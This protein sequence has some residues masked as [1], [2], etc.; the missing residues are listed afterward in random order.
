MF[1]RTTRLGIA[2][3]FWLISSWAATATGQLVPVPL[4]TAHDIDEYCETSQ[5]Q[6]KSGDAQRYQRERKRHASTTFSTFV[7]H[8]HLPILGYDE[9]RG[10][11]EIPIFKEVPIVDGVSIA[12][13]REQVLRFS[14][15]ER[16]AIDAEA[17]YKLGRARLEL[18]F[19]PASYAKWDQETCQQVGAARVLHVALLQARLVDE[20][21]REIAVYTSDLGREVEMLRVHR[22]DGYLGSAFP[23]VRITSLAAVETRT[24]AVEFRQNRL[25]AMARKTRVRE[26]ELHESV[27]GLRADA[28]HLL[29]G[30]YVRGLAQN[31]R[32]QGALVVLVDVRTPGDSRILVD[33]VHE[34]LVSKCALKRLRDLASGP[35]LDAE[36]VEK[37]RITAM[38]R[39]DQT[40]DL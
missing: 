34:P 2:L 8:D 22:V 13:E 21:R 1:H 15:I 20:S 32:L 37:L 16:E 12:L 24:E 36:E 4:E 10:A 27:A 5:P 30:C 11:V 14:L 7:G 18:R 23:S 31:A 25:A 17:L 19:L 28:E 3:I 38:F 35:P 33:S 26:R 9:V 39:L 6:E 29:F 40:G